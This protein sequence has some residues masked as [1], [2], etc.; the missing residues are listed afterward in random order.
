VGGLPR[1]DFLVVVN[2]SCLVVQKWWEYLSYYF[3]VPLFVI[4]TPNMHDEINR[5]AI[6]YTRRQL[7]ELIAWLE[8]HLGRRL[9]YPR[10]TQVVETAQTSGQLWAQSY[11]LN[12]HVPSPTTMFDVW[13]HNFVVL[14]MRNTQEAID[15]YTALIAEIKERIAQGISALPEERYRLYWDNIVMWFGLGWLGRKLAGAGAA[16]VASTYAEVFNWDYLDASRPLDSLAENACL[17]YLNRGIQHKI[18]RII[19]IVDEYAIDGLIM[20]FTRG[21]KAFTLDE[22]TVQDVVSQR[23]GVPAI[24]LDGDIVDS[25]YFSEADADRVIDTLLEMIDARRAAR[26]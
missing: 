7:L 1:P 25:R 10:L 4:D 2:D 19:E 17:L 26:K 21:C 22:L 5:D 13:A 24:R 20:H 6:A 8:G 12:K 11:A 3:Q 23:T 9:D 18:K 14:N 16:I 15:H